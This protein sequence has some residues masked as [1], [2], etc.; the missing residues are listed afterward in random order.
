MINSFEARSKPAVFRV[1]P[2][3]L[4][5]AASELPAN[6]KVEE[7]CAQ[8]IVSTL[9]QHAFR[10]PPTPADVT[11]LMSLYQSGRKEGSY[12]N[13]IELALQGILAHP[14]FIYRIEGEPTAT[15]PTT[16]AYRISDFE[17]AS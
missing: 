7:G 5:S 2:S 10:Q 13:G 9:A 4:M 14:K 8:R 1:S 12:D 15:T 16:P 17:L 6:A 11:K 3:I